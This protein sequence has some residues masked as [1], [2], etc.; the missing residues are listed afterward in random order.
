MRDGVTK[1]TRDAVT[2]ECEIVLQRETD[3]QGDMLGASRS[4]QI[5]EQ[6]TTKGV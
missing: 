1:A 4:D 5:R 6:L 2:K 3:R